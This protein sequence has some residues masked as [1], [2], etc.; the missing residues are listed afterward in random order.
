MARTPNL[1]PIST[2]IERIAK[3]AQEAPG[4]P[5][6]TIA[7]H[8]D[9]ELLKTAFHRTRPDGAVGVDGIEAEEYAGNLDENLSSLVDRAKS[10]TYR[11]PP[12]RRTYIPKPGGDEK[13]P[14]GIPTFEDKV[15]QRGVLMLLEPIYER[16]FR[17]CSYG[18]RPGRNCHQAIAS[19]RRGVMEERCRWLVEVDIRKFFDTLDHSHLQ[20]ILRQRVGD[21]VILRLIGKWLNA[22]VME[23]LDLSYPEKGTPQGGVISPLLAN[24]YL[25]EVLDVWFENVVKAHLNGRAFLVRYADDFVMGFEEEA[26]ARRVYGVLPKRFE[27]FGLM[28]H[29]EKTRLIDFRRPSERE[30]DDD[31]DDRRGGDATPTAFEFL[32][33]THIWVRSRTRKWIMRHITARSRFRRSL[34]RVREWLAEH[35]HWPIPEQHERLSQKLEGHYGYFG[36]SGNFRRIAMYKH[37][38]QRLW[39]RFLDRRSQRRLS[40]ATFATIVKRFPLPDPWLP[41]SI[42]RRPANA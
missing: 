33:F 36:L 7:H 35:F 16:D 17:D 10:G 2:R 1:L 27:K 34:L 23:G 11:A 3:L 5:I 39:Y 14:I 26:D 42:Y 24:I 25:H 28:L 21:G 13:R 40:W 18:F 15:L 9:V 19:M 4:T 38:V 41:H 32:G 31:E 8:L 30:G 37:E 22:G 12:V 29:P 6:R 20:S